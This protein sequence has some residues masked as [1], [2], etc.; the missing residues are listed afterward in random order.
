M[1]LAGVAWGA[2][3]L[4]GRNSSDPLA[5]TSGNF[6]RAIPL[7]LLF[8]LPFVGR[9]HTDMPGVIYAVLSGAI[10]SGIGYAIWYSAMRDLTSIQAATVQLSVPILA[11]FAGII[12]LGEQLTLRM[13]V[14]TLTVLLGI[15]LV[16]KARQR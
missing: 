11:A 8:S 12:L 2:Y 5:T 3:S 14:A 9:M 10:A 7:M 6:I 15:I 13:S 4:L 16:M 1:L